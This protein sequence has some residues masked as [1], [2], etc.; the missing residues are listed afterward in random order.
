MHFDGRMESLF[1]AKVWKVWTPS[2]I[3]P[4]VDAAKSYLD[5][6]SAFGV[7]KSVFLSTQLPQHGD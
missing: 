4:L 2:Q 6:Q 7:T 5:S 1:P 3:P